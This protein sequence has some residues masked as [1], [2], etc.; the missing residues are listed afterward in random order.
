M[1]VMSLERE[2]LLHPKCQTIKSL[3]KQ[4]S[5]I[6]LILAVFIFVILFREAEYIGIFLG[7]LNAIVVGYL[8]MLNFKWPTD[9][10]KKPPPTTPTI[11]GAAQ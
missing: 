5:I 9:C 2:F 10:Q 8:M 1:D 11:F 7:I 3:L 4:T 6:I